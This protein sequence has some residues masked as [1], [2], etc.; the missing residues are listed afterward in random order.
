MKA[1]KFLTASVIMS[2]LFLTSVTVSAQKEPDRIDWEKVKS[3]NSSTLDSLLGKVKQLYDKVF[4]MESIA[5]QIEAQLNG[6]AQV[7]GIEKL[8]DQIEQF[9]K[10][11]ENLGSMGGKF[12][13]MAGN[14][15]FLKKVKKE[16]PV[17]KYL[18]A[19]KNTAIALKAA[20]IITE[21]TANMVKIVIPGMKEKA[22]ALKKA[23]SQSETAGK[24]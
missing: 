2:A 24:L 8:I 12:L 15:E 14:E 20:K 4:L 10:E 3:T 5:T 18:R 21:K 16:V 19:L 1:I 23:K 7:G 22:T 6:T 13:D 11:F 17:V 9:A